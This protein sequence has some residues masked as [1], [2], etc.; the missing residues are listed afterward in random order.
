MLSR[1]F[2]IDIRTVSQ[3]STRCQIKEGVSFTAA[4]LN[5]QTQQ[6]S[7]T[8]VEVLIPPIKKYLTEVVL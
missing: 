5:S 4:C 3:L 1:S 2:Y 8:S 6:M 7:N